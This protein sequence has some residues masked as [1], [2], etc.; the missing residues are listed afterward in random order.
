QGRAP[1]GRRGGGRR[2]VG[3]RGRLLGREPAPRLR[4]GAARR[5]RRRPFEGR[6]GGRGRRS[7]RER[8]RLGGRVAAGTVLRARTHLRAGEGG[9]A[10][11]RA[12]QAGDAEGERPGDGRLLVLRVTEE[13]SPARRSRRRAGGPPRRSPGT[14]T[15]PRRRRS[16]GA[17]TAPAASPN[18]RRGAPRFRRIRSGRPRT[19]TG[20]ANRSARTSLPSRTWVHPGRPAASPAIRRTDRPARAKPVYP[21]RC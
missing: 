17:P 11:L 2:A 16:G 7:A 20:T 21:A 9:R 14:G 4:R 15:A 19:G 6:R 3:L 18:R 5:H 13:L 8:R 1:A 12:D 10:A